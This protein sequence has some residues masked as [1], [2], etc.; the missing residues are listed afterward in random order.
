MVSP[1]LLRR[2]P[3]FA[4]LDMDQITILARSAD[5]VTVETGHYF[6]HE[7]EELSSFYI[8]LEG[9]V[10]IVF[11]LPQHDREIVI[12][13]LGPGDVFAW[14][15]LVPPHSSTAS[16]KALTWC[17]VLSFDCREIRKSFEE[18]WHFGYLMME[19]AA[20]VIR[21]RLR[22]LRIESLAYLAEVRPENA[23]E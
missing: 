20:Q 10:A 16:G 21:G 15:G 8:I 23:R 3:F 6:F 22:D 18:D 14:S 4:G 5:E 17:R 1:E 9:A 19:K 11:E 12:S 13:T 7:G 2:Y